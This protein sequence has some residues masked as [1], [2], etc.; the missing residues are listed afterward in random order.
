M[1]NQKGVSRSVEKNYLV[2]LAEK[3]SKVRPKVGG[4]KDRWKHSPQARR[5]NRCFPLT[6]KQTSSGRGAPIGDDP[7]FGEELVLAIVPVVCREHFA[8]LLREFVRLA[9]GIGVVLACLVVA[10]AE[11]GAAAIAELERFDRIGWIFGNFFVENSYRTVQI[12][13]HVILRWG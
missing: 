4:E 6:G 8:Q 5:S 10:N 11:A 7:D 9:G 3:H 13:R 12:I 2:D 1:H